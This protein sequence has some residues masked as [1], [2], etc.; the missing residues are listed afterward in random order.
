VGRNLE[1]PPGEEFRVA[2]REAQALGAQVVL[3]D[4]PV[5]ITLARVWGALTSW[6][7]FKLTGSLLWAGLTMFDS[8]ALKKDI[9]R[10]KA[11]DS[12]EGTRWPAG[13]P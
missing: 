3:G 5:T 11:S 12:G 4:R 10:L 8:S 13:R 6:E 1:V 2:L 9:E 7:K